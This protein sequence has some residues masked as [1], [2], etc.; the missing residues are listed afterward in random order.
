VSHGWSDAK[1]AVRRA[2]DIVEL[3]GQYVQLRRSGRNYTGL[4]PWHDDSRPS[5]QVNPDRQSFKCWVCDIGGDVFSFVMK[6]EGVAFN[7]ALRMLAERAGISLQPGTASLARDDDPKRR[8][9]RALA[10]AARQFHE[11]LLT[12]TEA[13][14]ARDYLAQRGITPDS[15]QKFQLGYSPDSWSWLLDRA[16]GTE[17]SP[18][19]LE[20]VGL[21]VARDHG[22]G[23]YDRFR[24]RVLFTI[25]DT[26]GRPVAFGGRILPGAKENAGAK[27]INSPETPLFSKS[28]LVYGLDV[29]REACSKSKQVIVVEGYT[30]AIVAH[31]S[32]FPQTV[33]VLGTALGERHIHLLRRY[34]D[35][36]VLLLDGDAAGQRRT[37][38]VLELFVANQ[39]DLRVL[40]LPD[41]LDPCD[42]LQQRGAD[43]FRTLLDAAV[44][45]LEH[46]LRTLAR[47]NEPLSTHAAH[48]AV[49]EVLSTVAKAPRLSA[50]TGSSL[51][52]REEQVIHRLARIC[53]VPEEVL[54]KRLA[55]LRR[56]PAG[57]MRRPT[58]VMRGAE[59]R[60]AIDDP[61]ERELL[62]I[63]VQR[64]ELIERVLQVMG[65][66]ELGSE[67]CR[68]ICLAC[69]DLLEYEGEVDFHRLLVSFDEPEIKSLLVDLDERGSMKQSSP[70]DER[71]E[72][73]L[74]GLRRRKQEAESRRRLAALRDRNTDEQEGVKLLLEAIQQ[75][76]SR[77]CISESTDG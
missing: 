57:A 50:Q 22:T 35:Q 69:H 47:P 21:A 62:E 61:W 36:I 46:R 56:Q 12:S 2:V 43:E 63:V 60:V 70:V 10:W 72:L 24:G 17:M 28:N 45:A 77:H 65:P 48:Q 59:P 25:R 18:K 41:E 39:V 67:V 13:Q 42:F 30:D 76:R 55:D 6:V 66:D 15:I 23:H 58:D 51:R 31:Q 19:L 34:A 64:P 29:A 54:R 44:D 1:D 37:S 75:E 27:Y 3:V 53:E 11:C 71:L 8:M 40:T 33:A 20:T 14:A 74:A 52:L 4:C 26:Q 38:E 32:G 49:E 16:R 68:R 7:E 5:L 9:Y 73:L